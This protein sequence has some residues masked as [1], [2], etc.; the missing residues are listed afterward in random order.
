MIVLDIIYAECD[1]LTAVFCKVQQRN[2]KA[3]LDV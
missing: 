1:I 2:N 3:V